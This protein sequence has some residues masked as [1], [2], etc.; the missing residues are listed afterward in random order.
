ME[1]AYFHNNIF[2]VYKNFLKYGT[3]ENFFKVIQNLDNLIE[4]D[5][6]IYKKITAIKTKIILYE[7]IKKT[8]NQNKIKKAKSLLDKDPVIKLIK[9]KKIIKNKTYKKKRG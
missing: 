8:N 7:T 4:T 3:K 2:I 9:T 5:I 1:Y 6:P